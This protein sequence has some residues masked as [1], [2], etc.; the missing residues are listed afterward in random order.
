MDIPEA[1]VD[2]TAALV[3]SLLADQHPDLAGPPL[4][5]VAHGWDNV[6]LRLGDALAVRMP[7]RERAAG[8]ARNEQRRLGE[9]AA[10]LD[11]PVPTPVRVGGP[12]RGYP[13]HWSVVPWFEGRPAA[14]VP[15][16][17][18]GGLVA[19]LADFVVRLH[20]P[21]P[22]DA[23]VNPFRG[24]PLA[25]RDAGLRRRLADG[26]SHRRARLTALWEGLSAAPAWPGPPLW[27]HGDLHPANILVTDDGRDLSAVI[28]FGD[29]TSGD[30]ASDLAV[31]WL[32]FGPA[33]RAAFRARV[34]AAG[35]V[36]RHVWS[37]ARAWALLLGVLLADCSDDAPLLAAIGA[38]T[39]EQVGLDPN[40]VEID[41]D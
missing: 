29:L 13:W 26:P 11:T 9:I 10:R 38:H 19:P 12:G 1:E 32:L 35:V 31:A 14:T 23:P 20:V 40:P 37:R 27:L 16:A 22:T 17:D 41:R 36:D 15:V 6:I 2:V 8:L 34:D 5:L 24:V 39:L 30:P 28:D 21:A 33:D 18:R 7:R 25:E 3:R 4:T